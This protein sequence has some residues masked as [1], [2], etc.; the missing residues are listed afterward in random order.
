V[1]DD[2]N[3]TSAESDQS[4]TLELNALELNAPVRIAKLERIMAQDTNVR[5]ASG[6]LDTKTVRVASISE[7]PSSASPPR[8]AGEIKEK[9]LQRKPTG[10]AGGR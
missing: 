5:L 6:T 10:Y 7:G 4:H 9:H 1:L 3:R 2:R 8:R